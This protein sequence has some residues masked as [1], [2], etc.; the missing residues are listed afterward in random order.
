M[1][2]PGGGGASWSTPRLNAPAPLSEEGAAVPAAVDPD[3]RRAHGCLLLGTKPEP[4]QV[5]QPPPGQGRAGPVLPPTRPPRPDTDELP[6]CGSFGLFL[7]PLAHPGGGRGGGCSRLTMP[8][9]STRLFQLRNVLFVSQ[10]E[11]RKPPLWLAVPRLRTGT[12]LPRSLLL[13]ICRPMTR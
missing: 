2:V 5:T 3:P 7:S 4:P 13:Y 1:R 6:S 11:N 12:H 10:A 8:C 9:F